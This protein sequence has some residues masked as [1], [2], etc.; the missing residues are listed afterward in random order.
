LLICSSSHL[1]KHF[2][3]SRKSDIENERLPPDLFDADSEEG[4]AFLGSS[5]QSSSPTE[6][7]PFVPVFLNGVAEAEN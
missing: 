7:V 2:L 4:K 6:T 5:A 3:R 1:T